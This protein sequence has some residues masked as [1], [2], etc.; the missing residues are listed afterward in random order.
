MNA[1]AEN[2]GLMTTSAEKISVDHGDSVR[3]YSFTQ[4]F[5]RWASP[6][7]AIDIRYAMH[8]RRRRLEGSSSRPHLLR[9][10][11]Y[12]YFEVTTVT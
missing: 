1:A 2:A 8:H 9:M 4:P 6:T 10:S 11:F 5:E 12:V 3:D 7:D